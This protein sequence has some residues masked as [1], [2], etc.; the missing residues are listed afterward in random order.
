MRVLI[1]EDEYIIAQDLKMT[2]M[3]YGHEVIDVVTTGEDAIAYAS[4]Y[5]PDLI[6]MDIKLDSDLDGIEA[7]RTIRKTANIPI[8][9]CSAYVDRI[10]QYDTSLISPGIILAKPVI[11]SKIQMALDNCKDL[12]SSMMQQ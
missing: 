8:I 11:E 4:K 3:S 2:I 1:V 9:F 7:A 6:F 12:N 10:T 5:D